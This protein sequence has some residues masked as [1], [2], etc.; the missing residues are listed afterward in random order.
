MEVLFVP[1]SAASRA[2][3]SGV[4]PDRRR[5]FTLVELLVVI[6]IIG[7]LVSLLLP[8][9][10]AAREAA[11][12]SAC[13]NNLKQ[14]GLAVLNYHGTYGEFPRGCYDG[15]GLAKEDGLGWSSRILAELGEQPI[16]DQLRGLDLQQDF[17]ST[18]GSFNYAGNPW[19]PFIFRAARFNDLLPLPG[20]D[21]VISTYLCPS[22]DLPVVMP[23]GG[24]Y[25]NT[26]PGVNAGHGTTSY[27]GSR[28]YCDNGLFLRFGEM[29]S[30]DTCRF[31][32]N[33]DGIVAAEEESVIVKESIS[34]I[35]I[36]MITDG[37]SKTLMT[38]EA[39]Y[40]VGQADYPTW[41]GSSAVEDG[42]ILFKTR[43]PV[44][45]GIG[46]VTAFPV[47]DF[48][49]Q[50]MLAPGGQQDDCAFS[51]HPGGAMFGLADGSVRFFPE[52]LDLQLYQ[53]LGERNDGILLNEL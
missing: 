2:R 45:C 4:R 29:A 15:D 8:A 5:A 36:P 47:S 38:G 10:Q 44:N 1:V 33:R 28:G 16:D 49:S 24:F 22:S 7:I 17:G 18:L 40:T 46:G 31:D 37:T 41:V 13:S 32:L 20:G 48:D 50:R 6:A 25:G 26:S 53:L 30:R 42:A 21:A 52:D 34:R 39:A 27:K 19:Q 11:R 51:W 9:V 23:G 3:R 43:D 35:A 14:I 12:R